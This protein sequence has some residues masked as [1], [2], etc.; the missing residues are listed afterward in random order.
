MKIR[1]AVIPAA[2]FGTRFLPATKA[3]PKEMLPIVDKPVIQYV[4][5]EAVQSGIEEVILITGSNKRSLEDHFDYNFEL[6]YRLK[7]SGKK[8]MYDEIRR[9]SDM[10]KVVYVRQKE[11]LG[12][13]HAVLQARE[14]IGDEPFAVLWGDEV[15]DSPVPRL[16]QLI[17]TYERY[18]A[19]VISAMKVDNE[20]A[21][22]YGMIDGKLIEPRVTLVSNLIEKPGPNKTKSRLASMGGYVLTPAIFDILEKTKP[23]IGGEIFL[24]DAINQLSKEQAV[25]AYEFEGQL[26][27]AGS[28]LGFLKATVHYGL[29][30]E[31]LRDDFKAYLTS[32]FNSKDHKK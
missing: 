11:Q 9:I 22:K 5:E 23:G 14:L 27:D 10:V 1:K 30:H 13:G 8:E 4:V 6:E 25:Y 17:D 7:E 16:K 26:F 18:R 24:P 31:Y 29:K 20:G 28:K 15:V 2:G 32:V 19:S 12:N 21:S 3:S